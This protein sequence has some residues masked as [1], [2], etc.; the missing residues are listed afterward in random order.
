MR[1]K[2]QTGG[3]EYDTVSLLMDFDIACDVFSSLIK[4]P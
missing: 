1:M 3:Q 4:T 2:E